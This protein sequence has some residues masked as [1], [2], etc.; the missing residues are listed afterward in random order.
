MQGGDSDASTS[1]AVCSKAAN[2]VMAGARQR[3]ADNKAGEMTWCPDYSADGL[4]KL[5]MAVLQRAKH[6]IQA[7]GGWSVSLYQEILIQHSGAAATILMGYPEINERISQ[8]W[9]ES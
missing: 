6:P 3:R 2:K 9:E 7:A 1:L 5:S 4:N 8:H